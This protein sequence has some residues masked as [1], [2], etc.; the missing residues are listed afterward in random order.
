M[1]MEVRDYLYDEIVR[2]E[3]RSIDFESVIVPC[4]YRSQRMQ[5]GTASRSRGA[6][7]ML[8]GGLLLS[9]LR[10]LVFQPHP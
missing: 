5:R 9:S 2:S 4:D 10:R 1:L 6:I 3:L 8:H 7:C